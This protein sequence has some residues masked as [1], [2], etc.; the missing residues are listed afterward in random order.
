MQLLG[1]ALGI[2][3]FWKTIDEGKFPPVEEILAELQQQQML[4]MQQQQQQEAD[5]A[6]SQAMSQGMQN[7]EKR[8]QQMQSD[9][10]RIAGNALTALMSHRAKQEP[11]RKPAAK[12]K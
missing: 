2:K 1:T 5:A 9:R 10:T 4:A 8:N 11:S 7:T 6:K 3:S 12:N